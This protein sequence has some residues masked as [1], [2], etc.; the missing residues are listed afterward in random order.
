MIL[1]HFQQK[2]E[3]VL[4]R[5]MRKNQKLQRFQRFS[6]TGTAVNPLF[7]IKAFSA[8]CILFLSVTTGFSET[9]DSDYQGPVVTSCKTIGALSEKWDKSSEQWPE[10][11]LRAK[12]KAVHQDDPIAVTE[13]CPDQKLQVICLEYDNSALKAGDQVE[14]S[15][16]L[17][18]R[19]DNGV[20]IDPCSTR[21]QAD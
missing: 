1:E 16:M 13:L 11:T 21:L 19:F 20:V 12:V 2:C 10:I 6:P 15:G 14:V 8:T 9:L 17:T 5:I 18:N 7:Y 4:R 3:A